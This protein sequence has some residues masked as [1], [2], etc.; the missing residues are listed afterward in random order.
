MAGQPPLPPLRA[1]LKLLDRHRPRSLAPLHCPITAF[2]GA[3]DDTCSVA[4]LYTW[5]DLTV[6]ECELRIFPGGH[7]YLADHPR[8]VVAE[9]SHR[10]GSPPTRPA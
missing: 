8:E 2:G 1:D 5:Q 9:V 4:D 3:S 7:H 10:L 6:A